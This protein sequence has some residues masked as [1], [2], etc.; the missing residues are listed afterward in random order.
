MTNKEL[1]DWLYKNVMDGDP[2]YWPPPYVE[3][4]SS[5]FQVVEKLRQK[6]IFL[7]IYPTA[8]CWNIHNALGHYTIPSKDESLGACAEA[9]CLAAKKAIEEM[10]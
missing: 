3:S 5:A 8:D 10:G 4:I 7:D 2:G 1:N 9:I 6:C